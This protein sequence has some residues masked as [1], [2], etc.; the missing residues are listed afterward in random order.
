M[1]D[2]LVKGNT[3]CSST[4]AS[5]NDRLPLFHSSMIGK[6]NTHF[7]KNAEVDK[8]LEDALTK[9]KFSEL[10]ALWKKAQKIVFEQRVGIPMYFEWSYT[11]ASVKVNDLVPPWGGFNLVSIENNVWLSK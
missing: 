5:R 8:I 11:I 3:G 10:S 7:Y 6:S 4:T 9:T 1:G 2:D